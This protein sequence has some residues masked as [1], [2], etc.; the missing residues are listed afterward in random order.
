MPLAARL[1][2]AQGAAP[3]YPSSLQPGYPPQQQQQQRPPQPGAYQS[4]TPGGY[5]RPPPP[6]PGQVPGYPG[7]PAPY[8]Q[9]QQYGQQQ[10]G[11]QAYSQPQGYPPLQQGPPGYGYGGPPP[12]QQAQYPPQQ[13][14][15]GAPQQQQYQQPLQQ[16]YGAPQG[17]PPQG[18]SYAGGP[19]AGPGDVASYQRELERAVREKGLERF[20][21][22]GSPRIQQLAAR[23]PQEVDKICQAWK[24]QR[25]IANDIVRLALYDVIIYIDDSGSMAFE[26]NGERIKDL[27]LILQRVAFAATLFDD[28]GIELRFMNDEEIPLQQLSGIRSEQ[29][30]EQIMAKKRFKG[31][32][33]FGTK[34]R[35]KVLDPLVV[36]KLRSGQMQKPILIVG[37]TDGQPAGEPNDALASAIRYGFSHT[38]QYGQNALAF[39]FA[40]VGNDQKATEFLGKLDNDPQIGSMVDCTSN[41]E[42][43]SAEM[44]RA[45]PPV[46]LTPDL[47]MIKLILGAIDSSYD[48]KDEKT[49]MIG[50]A[51]LPPGPQAGGYGA[52]QGGYQGQQGGYGGQQQG[53]GGQQQGYGGQQQGYGG[54]Q[55]H[56]QGPPQQGGYGGQQGGYGG[57][58][59]GYG[60]QQG[61]Q[62][63]GYGGQQGYG[64]GQGQQPQGGYP[65]QGGYQPPP[66]PPRY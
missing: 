38:G 40:Q 31:L 25:E 65:P 2:S 62:Q 3:P 18:Q 58:Q 45:Q 51:P 56:G 6:P 12:P 11:Q 30:I 64:Q 21:P 53:Y 8:Y 5:S 4:P 59:G 13:Q 19:P 54:Q 60:G 26:E 33:P 35:E 44:A 10:Y 14:Y 28:D 23:A 36:P 32:T 34:L 9:Q 27:Q 47:W 24:I 41:Y 20:Y 29:Q 16:Q 66:G 15:G 1:A 57:Q 43:E 52:P 48:S 46:D 49:S 42:N 55:G 50:G 39:Q 7:Q 37:I 17:G 63:G 61:G 22:P